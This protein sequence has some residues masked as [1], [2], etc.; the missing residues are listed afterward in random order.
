MA[1][2]VATKRSAVV[3]RFRATVARR[4]GLADHV[5]GTL[6]HTHTQTLVRARIVP[7]FPVPSPAGL[8]SSAGGKSPQLAPKARR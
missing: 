8:I 3:T 1:P 2:S 4:S 5:I 7:V 6:T